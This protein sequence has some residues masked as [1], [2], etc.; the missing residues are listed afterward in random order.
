MIQQSEQGARDD[1]RNIDT[2]SPCTSQV[3]PKG[4]G[5][6]CEYPPQVPTDELD[7]EYPNRWLSLCNLSV[8]WGGEDGQ[9]LPKDSG[10]LSQC[11]IIPI[12]YNLALCIY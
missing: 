10:A 6:R 1:Q 7:S 11:R 8:H 4:V 3:T 2:I 12:R 5:R 9:S